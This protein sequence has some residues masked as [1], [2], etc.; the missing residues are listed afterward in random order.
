MRRKDREI[1]DFGRVLEIIRECDCCR[2]G[3]VDAGEA[4]V[5]PMNYGYEYAG[6][7]LTLYFHCAREGRKID[8]IPSQKR[9]F[10]EMDGKHALAAG[11]RDDEYTFLYHCVMGYGRLEII[12]DEAERQHGLQ[13][14]M[15]HYVDGH[16]WDFRPELMERVHVLRLSVYKWSC[17]EH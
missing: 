13:K 1:K 4:Y 10:F 6:G 12:E 5:V 3:L 15:E 7:K 16:S 14:L 17:K 9:V 8:L 2:L 11:S